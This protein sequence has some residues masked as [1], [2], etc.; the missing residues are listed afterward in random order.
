MRSEVKQERF[1]TWNATSRFTGVNEMPT[2]ATSRFTGVNEMPTRRA[3][4]EAATAVDN[5]AV[6]F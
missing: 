6:T 2:N 1:R 5:A 3:G 4:E